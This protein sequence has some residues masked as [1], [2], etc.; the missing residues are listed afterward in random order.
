MLYTAFLQCMTAFLKGTDAPPLTL[1]AAE[2]GKLYSLAKRQ[3]L[4]GAL[5]T[6]TEHAAMPD[7]VRDRL[8]RDGFLT[9]SRYEGQQW[10]VQQLIARFDALK[11]PHLFFKGTV[12][13]RYY[14]EPAMRS[15][16][17]IDFA[18]HEADRTRAETVLL[19]LGF[20]CVS[21]STEVWAYEQGDQLLE[22]HTVVRHFDAPAQQSVPYD[23]LWTDARLQSGH[24]Y[25]L[26]DEAEIVHTIHHLAAHFASSG[27]GLRQPMDVCVLY[28]RFA[29]SGLWDAVLA[30]LDAEGLGT[31]TRHLLWYCATYLDAPIDDAYCLPLDAEVAAALTARLLGDGTFGTD[32]RVLLASRRRE[33]RLGKKG[34]RVGSAARRLF[35]PAAYMRR[36]YEYADK[37]PWLIPAAYVHRAVDGVTKNRRIHERR[38]NYARGAEEELKQDIALFEALGL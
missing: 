10:I 23:T 1:S 8:R 25:H 5:F 18:V 27:C 36:R 24:T 28:D 22:M 3:S 37:H 31:F 20:T 9:L 17:D 6:V 14:R 12:V 13:R 15:M 7:S 21:R 19:E 29:D 26:S 34:G 4:S 2:W 30:R 35:P 33:E 16:G 38:R 32:S 11:I